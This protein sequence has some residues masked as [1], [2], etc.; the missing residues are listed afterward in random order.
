MVAI[1]VEIQKN[2]FTPDLNSSR[3]V[4][5]AL[6]TLRRYFVNKQTGI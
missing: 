3:E 6:H 1:G 5:Q 2:A 4:L